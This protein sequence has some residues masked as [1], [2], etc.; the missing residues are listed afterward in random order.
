MPGVKL[1]HHG[2][3]CT[4]ET[5]LRRQELTD[6]VP[7]RLAALDHEADLDDGPEAR[8]LDLA[9][10]GLSMVG[11]DERV[12]ELT[13]PQFDGAYEF[14]DRGLLLGREPA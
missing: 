13:G 12:L 11:P 9:L 2:A 3:D 8:G 5:W 1:S 7:W 6:P 14:F 4:S 10:R